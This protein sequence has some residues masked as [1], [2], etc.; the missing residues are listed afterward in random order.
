MYEASVDAYQFTSDTDELVR[1]HAH[2]VKRIALHLLARL[3]ASIQL[4][5]LLQAGM[6]GLLEASTKY[7]AS[8]GAS[9]AT[10]AGIR[11]RGAMLDEVRR[12][13]W[14]PR[15]VHR[16]GRALAEAIHHVEARTGREAQDKDVAAHMGLTIAEYH[17]ILADSSGSKL[18]SFEELMD[19]DENESTTRQFAAA[20]AAQ[21]DAKDGYEVDSFKQ[22][23]VEAIASLPER[24]QLVL[25]L[26]YDEE[27]NLKEIGEVIGVGESRVSQ[28]MSQATSRLRG[29]LEE[30]AQP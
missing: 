30:W 6:L 9:F 22:K 4:D 18:F 7:D 27:L 13:D 21:G 15:S 24:D 25:S 8:R 20:I 3:P 23:L 29:K 19:S 16:N 5:D 28:I 11:I 26:Y 12:G 14:V 10:Y 1:E 17:R 2:L